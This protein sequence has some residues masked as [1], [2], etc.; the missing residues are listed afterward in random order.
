M[1]TYQETI[2]WITFRAGLTQ[3]PPS[4]WLLLGELRA[5]LTHL[6]GMPMVVA[7]ARATERELEALGTQARLALDGLLL[8][9]EQ[10]RA[11]IPIRGRG[12]AARGEIHAVDAYL[13]SLRPTPRE[14]RKADPLPL[15]PETLKHLHQS[16]SEGSTEADRPGQWRGFPTGGRAWEGVP[17]EVVGL[18]TEELC[19]WLGSDELA[20]PE[21]DAAGAYAIL[22]MLLAELYLAWIRPFDSAHHRTSGAFGAALLRAAGMDATAVHLL[23]IALHR[24]APAFQRHIQQATEGAADP[25]PFATFAL[26]RMIEVLQGLHD[27][28]REA[29]L[30]GQWRAQLL[31][32]FQDG[33]DAPTRRQRQVLLDLASTDRPVPLNR[34]DRLSPTL[35]KLYADVSEKTLRRDVDALLEAGV[36]QREADGLRVDLSNLL[37]FKG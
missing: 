36:I 6:S 15:V 3:A 24:H 32:L 17:P 19:D 29:Q 5:G 37:A 31:E 30:R 33:N 1:R 2:T 26:R 21:P 25:I 11:G 4:L 27:R 16:V 23:S 9:L 34:I 7:E 14:P 20:A 8:P 28:V 12:T 18:F 35:A 22:R 10:V 13:G